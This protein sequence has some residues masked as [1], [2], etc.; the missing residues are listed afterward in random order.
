MLAGGRW[1]S[2]FD[3]VTRTS[4]RPVETSTV[5]LQERGCM[6]GLTGTRRATL[7]DAKKG[8]VALLPLTPEVRSKAPQGTAV[9][10]SDLAAARLHSLGPVRASFPRVIT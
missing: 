8:K 2:G 4:L 5:M 9:A 1:W 6:R 3:N 7:H 10:L